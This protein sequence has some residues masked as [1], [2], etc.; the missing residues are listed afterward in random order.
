MLK[1]RNPR[2]SVTFRVQEERAALEKTATVEKANY[3]TSAGDNAG[4]FPNRVRTRR[5]IPVRV[6]RP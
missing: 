2:V 4:L 5:T 6:R 3:A 1:F